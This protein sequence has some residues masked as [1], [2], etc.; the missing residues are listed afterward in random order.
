[1]EVS[2]IEKDTGWAWIIAAACYIG[3][4]LTLGF[5]YS[6]GIYYV[7]FM[8]T[9]DETPSRVSWISSINL[10]TLCTIGEHT[11]IVFTA[12]TRNQL[13]ISDIVENNFFAFK[14]V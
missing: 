14:S 9:F 1:M 8:E 12:M 11:C 7:I 4:F 10:G 6:T 2:T 3:N 13:Q 5:S